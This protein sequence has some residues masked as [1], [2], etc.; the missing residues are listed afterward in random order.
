MLRLLCI[1]TKSA[2]PFLASLL[3]DFSELTDIIIVY[4]SVYNLREGEMRNSRADIAYKILKEKIDQGTIA[5]GMQ[6]VENDLCES[7]EMSRTP[8]REALNRLHAEGY[9]DYSPGKGFSA[10]SYDKN[11]I[12]QIYEMI[13][14]VEGMLAYLLAQKHKELDLTDMK[15][16]V[17]DMEAALKVENWDLWTDADSRFHEYMYSKCENIYIAHDVEQLNRPA[18][19]VR[20]MIT[21]VYIDKSVSTE[22]HRALYEAI[23]V[24]DADLARKEAQLH[25]SWV[26]QRVCE[27]L[28]SYEIL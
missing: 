22:S 28:D 14:A 11:K 27:C 26:R 2:A 1:I 21:R 24:G 18:N 9:L 10:T 8:V 20:Q 25:F 23:K 6:I 17:E 16:A 19:K 4:I 13:E 7:L 3:I 15:R 12:R 5:H